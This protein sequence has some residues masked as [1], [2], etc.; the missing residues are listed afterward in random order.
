M[1]SLRPFVASQGL[2]E[3]LLAP[4]TPLAGDLSAPFNA[5]CHDLLDAQRA[6]L[7]AAGPLATLSSSR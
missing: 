2:Y 7:V 1:D 3:R 5:L 4:A 6:Y